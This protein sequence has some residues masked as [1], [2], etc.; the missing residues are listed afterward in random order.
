MVIR[1]SSIIILFATAGFV[2]P[3]VL[4]AIDCLS[5][6]GFWRHWILY[7]FPSSYMLGAASGI[8]DSFFYEM[9]AI[10]IVVNIMLYSIAGFILGI[11]LRLI[12]RLHWLA[13]SK[14]DVMDGLNRVERTMHDEL[15]RKRRR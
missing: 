12:A 9:A 15:G 14:P 7:V 1:L 6:H 13:T 10:A 2:I 5:A 4:V 8:I 11:F 3:V